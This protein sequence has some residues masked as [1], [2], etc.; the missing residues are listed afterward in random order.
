MLIYVFQWSWGQLVGDSIR[1][2]RFRTVVDV[3]GRSWDSVAPCG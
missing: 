3:T 1:V 2:L